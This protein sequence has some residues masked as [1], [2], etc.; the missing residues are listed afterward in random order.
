ML[1]NEKLKRLYY[2][3]TVNEPS[4]NKANFKTYNNNF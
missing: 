3:R 1:L 4:F 2:C